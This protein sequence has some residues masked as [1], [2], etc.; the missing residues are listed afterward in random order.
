MEAKGGALSSPEV[1]GGPE[2]QKAPHVL[3]LGEGDEQDQPKLAPELG[4]SKSFRLYL[5]L[6]SNVT[7]QKGLPWLWMKVPVILRLTRPLPP[8]NFTIRKTS[9]LFIY[10]VSISVLPGR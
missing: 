3:C 10:L 6:S 8:F 5:G 2:D 7:L 1:G 9:S 4:Q